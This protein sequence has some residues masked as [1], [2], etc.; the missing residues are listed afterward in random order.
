MDQKRDIEILELKKRI[1]EVEYTLDE[2][3][4][5]LKIFVAKDYSKYLSDSID[6]M[7]MNLAVS[8]DILANERIENILAE[9]K[10]KDSL[11]EETK[12][13][14]IEVLKNKFKETRKEK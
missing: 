1:A 9:K 14:E 12:N 6:H 11:K 3:L 5:I 4:L 2:V 13:L 7:R 8:K 10:I